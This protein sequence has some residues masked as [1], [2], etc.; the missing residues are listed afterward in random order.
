ME[1]SSIKLS[2]QKIVGCCYSMD[3]TCQVKI[4]LLHRNHQR[5]PPTRTTTWNTQHKHCQWSSTS[6]FLS[7]TGKEEEN[8]WGGGKVQNNDN[9]GWTQSTEQNRFTLPSYTHIGMCIIIIYL[10]TEFTNLYYT[11]YKFNSTADHTN[12]TLFNSCHHNT[13]TVAEITP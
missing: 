13:N 10:L 2:C 4:K 1:N 11:W 3:V 9:S 12:F 7:G 8:T 5:I 6:Q